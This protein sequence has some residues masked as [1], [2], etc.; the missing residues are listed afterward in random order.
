MNPRRTICYYILKLTRL[1]GGPQSLARG[2]SIGI[3][4][5]ITPILPFHTVINLLVTFLTRTSTV[6]SLLAS[7]LVYNPFTYIPQYYL[8]IVIGNAVT[9]YNLTWER[10]K[11]ILDTLLHTSDIM[12]PLTLL[13]GIGSEAITILLAGGTILALPFT[14]ASYFLSLRLFTSIHEKQNKRHVLG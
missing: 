3:F 9:P 11:I 10:M 14:I 1:K 6:A 2:T 8:S 7:M 12:A 13:A 5:V 4:F